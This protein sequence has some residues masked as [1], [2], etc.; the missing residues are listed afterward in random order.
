M[1]TGYSMPPGD[2]LELYQLL[3]IYRG[4]Y[5]DRTDFNILGLMD[6]VA[7]FYADR[8]GGKDIRKAT[9]PRGA[10][11]KNQYG[12]DKAAE[13][14]AAYQTCKSI[15]RTAEQTGVSTTYVYKVIKS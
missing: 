12:K 1:A 8:T 10:G 15:R 14:G 9:N 2:L 4:K 7:A 3:R 6:E 13:V 5:S 11:R